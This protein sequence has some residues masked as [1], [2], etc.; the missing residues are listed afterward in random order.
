MADRRGTDERWN[1]DKNH[2]LFLCRGGGVEHL[3]RLSDCDLGEWAR[4][5]ERRGGRGWWVHNI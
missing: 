2:L 3:V 5:R 1:G 4:E